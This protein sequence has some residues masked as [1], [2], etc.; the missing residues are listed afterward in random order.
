MK[1]KILSKGKAIP[2]GNRSIVKVCTI[3]MSKP[4][5]SFVLK[6]HIQHFKIHPKKSIKA[7][8]FAVGASFGISIVKVKYL[9][10]F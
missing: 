10:A 5:I 2:I 4:I 6:P 1:Q 8:F 7:K 9:F 3:C